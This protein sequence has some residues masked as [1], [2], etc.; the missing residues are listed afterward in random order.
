MR[1]PWLLTLAA[2]AAFATPAQLYAQGGS[3]GT[4]AP[5]APAQRPG[6]VRPAPAPHLPASVVRRPLGSITTVPAF[7]RGHAR[8]ARV[9]RAPILGLFAFDPYFWLAPDA[10]DEDVTVLPLPMPPPGPR[11]TGGLQLDVDPRRALVYLD[12]VLV[13]TVD[14]FKGYF[15]HLE[16]TAGYH[17]VEFISPD[18]DPMIA[19]VT[20][21]PNQTTTYRASMNRGSGR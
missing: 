14:H 6:T 12:G 5:V 20:V 8:R 21:V 13:G 10:V 1:A 2:V 9:F 11:L 15:Q 18:Y 17:V 16:T 4:R 7:P 19:E 3:M